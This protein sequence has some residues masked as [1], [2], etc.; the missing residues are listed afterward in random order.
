LVSNNAALTEMGARLPAVDL[1]A[2]R[3]ALSVSAGSRHTCA[4]LVIL[5]WEVL[6]AG[7][8]FVSEALGG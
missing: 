6:G 3:T 5:G 4:L 7:A 1:G 2:D 8:R